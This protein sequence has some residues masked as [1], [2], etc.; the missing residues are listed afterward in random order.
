MPSDG[1][2][3]GSI[4]FAVGYQIRM[5]FYSIS[6]RHFT[7]GR[8]LLQPCS[9]SPSRSKGINYILPYSKSSVFPQL[10]EKKK[11]DFGKIFYKHSEKANLF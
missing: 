9:L 5:V 3:L 4:E 2:A 1:G 8:Q 6:I 7:H 10:V 11:P